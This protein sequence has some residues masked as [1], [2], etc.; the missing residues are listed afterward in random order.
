LAEMD[1]ECGPGR[2]LAL[3]VPHY[4][5][6]R[7]EGRS[8]ADA[9]ELMLRSTSS[10]LVCIERSD[11]GKSYALTTSEAMPQL[12]RESDWAMTAS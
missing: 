6:N 8:P 12:C 2:L 10:E 7:A 11:G 9:L 4:P 3:I 5:K 1:A